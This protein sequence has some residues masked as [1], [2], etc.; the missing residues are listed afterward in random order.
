MKNFLNHIK[1][2]IFRG[3]LAA[4]PLVL[5]YFAIK[6]IY[7]FIDKRVTTLLYKYIGLSIPGLG[8]VLFVLFLYLLG[9]M[10]SNV[11]GKTFFG[12]VEKI[13]NRI[14]IIN[15]TYEV[16]KQIAFTLS[17]P[18]K[19]VFK[20]VVFVSFKPGVWAIGFVTG[21]VLDKRNKNEKFLKVFIPTVPNPTTGFVMLVKE[22]EIIPSKWTVDEGMRSVISGGIIG[23]EVLEP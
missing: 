18:E 9:L 17:L 13:L 16:G 5:S 22:S 20:Q 11:I 6:F 15:T 21:T 19:Q 3:F 23:P 7:I 4:I 10:A 2:H 8:L 12:L 14:P 1:A